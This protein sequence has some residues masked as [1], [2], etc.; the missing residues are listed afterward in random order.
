MALQQFRDKQKLIYWIISPI[1]ILSFVLLGFTGV[2]EQGGAGS[3]PVGRY[4]GKSCSYNDF[5]AFHRDL[6]N[7]FVYQR[8]FIGEIDRFGRFR[9]VFN[10]PQS[11]FVMMALAEDARRHG[12]EVTDA[13][14]GTFLRHQI[15]YTGNDPKEFRDRLERAIVTPSRR[16]SNVFEYQ[17]AARENLL[18][19]KFLALIDDSIIVPETFA[20]IRTA[21][22][23]ATYS[24]KRA[25]VPS[26]SQAAAAA[27]EIGKLPPAELRAKAEGFIRQNQVPEKR[28]QYSYLWEEPRWVLEYVFVPFEVPSRE[29]KITE[30]KVKNH[31]EAHK[32]DYK[33]EKGEV[34][35]LAAVREKVEADI[36]RRERDQ[37]AMNTIKGELDAF[38][39]RREKNVVEQ[40]ELV[41]VTLAE[42]NSDPRLASLALK[43][44]DT[45]AK[46]RTIKEI[47]AD[48]ALKDFAM[49][50]NYAFGEL[51]RQAL[52]KMDAAAAKARQ[53]KG[54]TEKTV[55]EARQ[56][57][58]EDFLSV[59][60]KTFHGH[61]IVSDMA[62][63]PL[64]GE[65]GLLKFR[66]VKYVPGN[67][68]HLEAPNAAEDKL[69]AEVKRALTDE[70]TQAKARQ[71]AEAVQAALKEK[72]APAGVEVKDVEATIFSMSPAQGEMLSASV[73]DVS[74]PALV[75]VPEAGYEVWQ[76]TGVKIPADAEIAADAA[77][78]R[79]GL[80]FAFRSGM[81][82]APEAV[83]SPWII[84]GMRARSYLQTRLASQEIVLG[85][86]LRESR[87]EAE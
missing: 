64:R 78:A 15:Q 77:R 56:Q 66:V 1:V 6:S 52:R 65:S 81:P 42:L 47:F 57:A 49:S 10:E 28:D 54:A 74:A 45:G 69:L 61:S 43:A 75:H 33:N 7:L 76:L 68:R 63:T 55:S 48:A 50:A 17:S 37:N 3:A 30:E 8:T 11:A 25:F 46:E 23:R 41:P 16:F 12:V 82:Y 27:E 14:V 9:Q 2:F 38:I 34:M 86:A 19:R 4:F 5:Y 36:R 31:Y 62:E 72:R 20:E 51:D 85:Q 24:F 59:Y 21:Q 79:A 44:G 80:N 87:D 22:E 26:A 53:Q 84:I 39:R 58:L 35:E 60:R 71:A 29:P 73:G 70:L 13:E 18:A 32:N 67:P 40:D 83:A